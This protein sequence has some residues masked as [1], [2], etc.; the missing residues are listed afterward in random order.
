[1]YIDEWT[2]FKGE[3]IMRLIDA[4]KLIHNLEKWSDISPTINERNKDFI[5]IL[6]NEDTV[7]ERKQGEWIHFKVN[8][9]HQ[10][11]C[12]ECGYI[13]P[14]YVTFIRNFCPNCGADMRGS[15]SEVD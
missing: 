11:K 13:E 7:E 3:G 1:M 6:K 9:Q 2:V 5:K 15:K 14:E 12:P 4:D 10:I 8:G